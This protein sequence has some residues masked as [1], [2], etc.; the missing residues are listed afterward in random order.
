M[1]EDPLY[2]V[3]YLYAGL[4]AT[5][6]FDMAMKDPADFQRRYGALMAEGFDAPPKDVMRRFFG[7][8]MTPG[9]LVD[10][11][12]ALL[13]AKTKALHELYDAIR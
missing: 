6:M 1:Y 10:A 2:L 13:R 12:M 11:D 4:W 3:N 8:E 5:K 9:D 7:H